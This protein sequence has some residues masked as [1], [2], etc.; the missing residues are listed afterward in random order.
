MGKKRVELE[1]AREAE[2]LQELATAVPEAVLHSLEKTGEVRVPGNAWHIE[3]LL[4][5]Y[6][7]AEKGDVGAAA[8]RLARHAHWRENNLPHGEMDDVRGV[9]IHFFAEN[10]RPCAPPLLSNTPP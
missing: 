3:R 2:L 8:A 4:T 9:D 1:P 6:L 7:R 5:R 10:T